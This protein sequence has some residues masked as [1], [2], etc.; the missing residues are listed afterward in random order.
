MILNAAYTLKIQNEIKRLKNLGWKDPSIDVGGL[1]LVKENDTSLFSFPHE[2]YDNNRKPSGVWE[3]QRAKST[4][5]LIKINEIDLI[6][7]VGAGNGSMALKL[8]EYG[9]NVICVE[10]LLN[11]AKFLNA[12][13]LK[14][15][16]CTLDQL[17][18]PANSINAIGVFDVLE[19]LDDPSTLLKEI[20]RVLVPNGFLLT[21]V[22]AGQYL[23]SDFD[24]S[25]GHFR[26]YNRKK[27][28][29]EL[30][31]SGFSC[32]KIRY[33][34]FLLII[35]VFFARTLRYKLGIKNK[36]PEIMK[37]NKNQKKMLNKFSRIID[38]FLELE[39]KVRLPLG[40]SLIAISK[41]IK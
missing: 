20:Y 36:T 3:V 32:T 8:Q 14:A 13:N 26:R 39:S 23:F 28:V 21:T 22:P 16:C 4:Y 38:I 40:F 19:H 37:T 18:L 33:Q 31:Q 11:G 12:E 41:C 27:L 2:L 17:N 29:T 30:K 24:T 15:Y 1:S 6:W 9:T 34:F 25:I 7:E 10:P 35:P 5:E